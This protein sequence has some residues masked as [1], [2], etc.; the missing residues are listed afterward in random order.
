MEK[1]VK[2]RVLIL[3][4]GGTIGMATTGRG[5][6]PQKRQFHELLKGMPE[7]YTE[8]MPKWEIQDM[9]P[10]LDSSNIAVDEWNAIGRQVA[11]AYDRYDGFVILHGTDT[12]AY[13]ASALSFMLEGCGKPVILTGSQIPLCEIRSDGRDNLVSSILLAADDRIHEVCLY[14]GGKL[15]R[16][17]RAM[18]YSADGLTAFRSPNYPVLAEAGIEMQFRDGALLPP[19]EGKR[20]TFQPFRKIPIGVIK[21]F[22]GIQFSLFEPILTENLKGLVIET[23]GTGNIPGAESA[24]IPLIRKAGENGTI[25]VVCS[26]CPQGKVRLGTYETSSSLLDAGAVSGSDLTTEAAVAKLYYLFSREH[27]RAEI[28]RKME[29]DLR[30][31]CSPAQA[32]SE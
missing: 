2:K 28:V 23:F 13:T 9:D 5:Y 12:M 3:Y 7:L 19:E 6:A 21:V 29:E 16:G 17:N 20:F 24:L 26:Q 32:S 11:Q 30:G 15:L 22:P 25:L 1:T 27:S 14:F 18:K 10:L 4:T 31:E 8:G